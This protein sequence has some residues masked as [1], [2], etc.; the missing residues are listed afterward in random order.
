V[1]DADLDADLDG[2]SNLQEYIAGTNPQ[3]ATSLLHVD[4]LTPV[5]G[6]VELRFE[7]VA[8][9]SYTVLYCEDLIDGIWLKLLDVPAQPASGQVIVNAPGLSDQPRYFRIVTPARP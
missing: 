6:S 9:K 5:I 8:G 7:A 3:N 1:N 4:S 2:F